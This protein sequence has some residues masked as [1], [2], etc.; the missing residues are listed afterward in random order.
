MPPLS[1]RFPGRF[2]SDSQQGRAQGDGPKVTERERAQNKDFRRFTPSSGNS[3]ICRKPQQTA[4][5][6]RK[7]KK[8]TGNRRLGSITL[9]PSPLARPSIPGVCQAVSLTL[10]L[11]LSDFFRELPKPVRVRT[12]LHETPRKTKTNMY[13]FVPP[14]P[15]LGAPNPEGPNLEN[16]QDR[17][18]GLKFSSEIETNDIFKWDWKFQASHHQTPIFVGNSQGQDWKFQARLKFSTEIENFKRKLEIFKRSS[19]I[20]FFQDSG[21]LGTGTD[22]HKFAPPRGRHPSGGP[23]GSGGCKF[24]FIFLAHRNRSDFC[25]LRLRCPSR[26]P[27]NRS[28]SETREAMP[29]CDLRVRWKVASD[30]RFRAAISESKT[31]SFCE[32]SGDLAPSTRKSLAI[33]IVRFWCAKFILQR[34]AP[35]SYLRV[36]AVPCDRKFYHYSNYFPVN[37]GIALHSLYRNIFRL[38]QFCITLHFL[39]RNPEVAPLLVSLHYI[40]N[41]GR[42]L[43]LRCIALWLKLFT[44]FKM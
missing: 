14:R 8:T 30:L 20:D 38:K 15:R 7:P 1:V 5:F 21:P 37:F 26:T 43:M 16:F 24:R 34:I 33:A 31:P 17:P 36:A 32:I 35:E 9:G 27:R 42:K 18:L 6:R 39:D 28:I 25:D 3:S 40:K 2:G 10:G 44:E 4:D 22:L 13:K 41:S 12:Y 19:E 23:T 29:H 11:Y